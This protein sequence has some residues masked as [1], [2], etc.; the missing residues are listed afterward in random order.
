MS[1]KLFTDG[2]FL[3]ASLAE[4]LLES[5]ED[6]GAVL[7]EGCLELASCLIRL[8]DVGP[9]SLLAAAA[10]TRRTGV[11]AGGKL[12]SSE[13]MSSRPSVAGFL[14]PEAPLKPAE[15]EGRLSLGS[16]VAKQN[17]AHG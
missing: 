6:G 15:V 1:C 11:L 5:R 4:V 8:E 16:P 14:L 17:V 2:V 9:A 13:L 7:F 12:S 10:L 3:A